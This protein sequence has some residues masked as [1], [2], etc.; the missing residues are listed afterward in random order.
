MGLAKRVE[1]V[2]LAGAVEWPRGIGQAKAGASSSS[3]PE[4][5][6]AEHPGSSRIFAEW[7]ISNRGRSRYVGLRRFRSGWAW[8]THCCLYQTTARNTRN[9]SAK[10]CAPGCPSPALAQN[11][12]S[13]AT[14]RLA[15]S[16]VSSVLHPNQLRVPLTRL[17]SGQGSLARC[18]LDRQIDAT[19][20]PSDAAIRPRQRLPCLTGQNP[21]PGVPSSQWFFPRAL[22]PLTPGSPVGAWDRIF[23]TD[24]GF[25]K[26]GRL[27]T[28]SF[29]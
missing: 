7:F 28:P 2:R 12:A 29:V 3:L 15:C 9:P 27:A 19:M 20:S 4:K 5:R 11:P 10:I 21:E 14:R 23:P 13:M 6:P 24:A 1:C 26:S 8:R 25:T 17:D 18:R 16:S 22:S